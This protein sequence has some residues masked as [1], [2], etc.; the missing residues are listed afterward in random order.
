MKKNGPQRFQSLSAFPRSSLFRFEN[1]TSFRLLT[2]IDRSL[3]T[4]SV[5][6]F[7]GDPNHLPP[8]VLEP[9]RCRSYLPAEATEGLERAA[10]SG[11]WRG[12]TAEAKRG[13]WNGYWGKDRARW[14]SEEDGSRA[15]LESVVHHVLDLVDV[16]LRRLVK[17]NRII[18][19]HSEILIPMRLVS[20]WAF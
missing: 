17:R 10:L 20:A 19:R 12:K 7:G 18:V 3:F 9:S 4:G 16:L 2:I 15:W 13:G 6:V 11:R 1:T 8:I 14:T 5:N